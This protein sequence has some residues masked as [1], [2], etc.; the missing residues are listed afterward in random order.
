[1]QTF[2]EVFKDLNL[3]FSVDASIEHIKVNRI[4]RTLEIALNHRPSLSKEETVE[5][6]A[7]IAEIYGVGSISLVAAIPK[8]PPAP[9]VPRGTKKNLSENVIYGKG[10]VGIPIDAKDV[11]ADSGKIEITGTVFDLDFVNIRGGRRLVKFNIYDGTGSISCKI[12][13][14]D[15][16]SIETAESSLQNNMRIKMRGE[17]QYDKFSSE[18]VVSCTYIESMPAA[19]T[20]MDN[21]P[22]KRVE[23]HLH[24]Q[25]SAMDGL[26]PAK[27]LV[28]RAIAWGHNAI[29]ITDHGVVQAF[30]DAYEAAKKEKDF[31]VIFGVEGY[32]LDDS[33]SE[34]PADWK[35]EDARFGIDAHLPTAPDAP[36]DKKNKTNHITILAKNQE[37][38]FNLYHLISLAHLDNFF[39]RPR[40]AKSLLQQCRQGLLIGSACELGELFRAMTDGADDDKLKE[41]ASF[42]DYL[43]VMPLG[44]NGFMLQNGMAREIEDLRSFNRRILKIGEELKIP[45][46]ATGDVHFMD[47]EDSIFRAILQ[48]G[49]GFSDADNQAPLYLRTTEEMLQ[50]FDYLGTEKA[51]EVVVTNTRLIADMI[52]RLQPIPEETFT[53]EIGDSEQTIVDMCKSK[54]CEIYGDRLPEIVQERMDKE[55]GK[56]IKYGFAVM[57]LIAQKVVSKSLEDGYLVG[58]R[59]SVGSSFVAFL[60]GITEVNAL[61]AHYICPDCKH[62]EFVLD[63]GSGIDLPSKDCPKCG[64]NFKTDGHDIPFETF[65]GFEGDKEPDIDLNFSGEYQSTAHK[66]VE[67]LFGNGYVFR[68]GTIGTLARKTAYGFVKKYLDERGKYVH[69][70]E[71]SRLVNGCIGVRRTTGQHPGGLM[72][73]PHG[74]NIHEF[75]PVQHPADDKKK[76]IVT[77]H[78]DYH[79]IS[80]RLLKLDMLG[81][82]DP[83]MIRMLEDLTGLDAKTIPLDDPATM[84]IFLNTRT[85]GVTAEQIGS[86][87]GTYGVPEFGTKFVRQLLVDTKPKTFSELVRISGLS[88]GT[89]VWTGNA[90]ELIKS[91]T[92]TLAEAICTRDDIMTYLIRNCLPPKESFDI[93]ERVRKGKKLRPEDET[94]M[95]EYSIP[96]WYIDSCNK[97]QYMFPKAH[98]VAYVT[99]AFRIAYFKVHYKKAFA[100]AYL[101]VRADEFDADFM[102]SPDSVNRE[103]ARLSANENALNQKEKNVVTILQ[104]L[105]EMFARGEKFLPVDL[106]KSDVRRFSDEPD[107]IR[108]PLIAIPGMGETAAQTIED[109]RQQMDFASVEDFHKRCK[110]NNSLITFMKE[111]GIFEGIPESDQLSFF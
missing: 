46:V 17:A 90:Q 2:D 84:E 63:A 53:P 93:M 42:Y 102:L 31:K 3:G 44:N 78:F 4:E 33:K 104:I 100:I 50:D 13:A 21:S 69:N 11:T 18:S 110:V 88:H 47:P 68:A 10:T 32:L 107:G 89:D 79:S 95:R 25:M 57:Y 64:A 67:E 12:V 30:P 60:C 99:M 83:T 22:E 54:A 86:S 58:S 109:A 48:S 91:G 106:Y 8:T 55:L 62:H 38:L 49:L 75:S 1:M 40:I 43:E 5:L 101:S 6:K 24:T 26:T 103:L 80:G 61:P 16:K 15:S 71:V 29:A 9:S 108:P 105:R 77:T 19:S 111:A 34:E 97:I 94:L 14:R 87:V 70:A 76:N 59:G 20:R 51:Y 82:D 98:A 45:V 36:L 96:E 81:H 73:L 72:I 85:L 65:L 39:K 41:I 66:Y 74:H 37:G 92:A 52:E 7:R 27:A 23:L 28:N 35:E 56:I